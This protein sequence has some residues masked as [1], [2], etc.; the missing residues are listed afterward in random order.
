MYVYYCFKLKIKEN[1]MK[2]VKL[3]LY[4]IQERLNTKKLLK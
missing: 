3:Q 2:H 1:I 4:E